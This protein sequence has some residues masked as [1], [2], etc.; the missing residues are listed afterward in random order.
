MQNK[1][2]LPTP[3]NEPN[4]NSNKHLR[5]QTTPGGAKKQSQFQTHRLSVPHISL[6]VKSAAQ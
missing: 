3:A 4:L 5:T 6:A 1:A 2:N